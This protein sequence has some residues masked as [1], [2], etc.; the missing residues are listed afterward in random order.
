MRGHA[1]VTAPFTAAAVAERCGLDVK[2][3]ERGLTMLE[4]SGFV[5]RGQ[6]S[7][8]ALEVDEF[9]DRR[10]LARI[11]RYTLDRLRREI[12]PVAK[13]DYMRFLLRWHGIT[14]SERLEGRGGLRQALSKLQGFEA[15]AGAW[16]SELLAARVKDY[17]PSWL[18]ELCLAGEVSWARLTPRRPRINEDGEATVTT[19]AATR[20]TPVTL[21]LRQDLGTLLAATRGIGRGW[22]ADSG[23]GA[24]P[25]TGAAAEVLSTL[26]ER[27]AL[28]FDEIVTSTRR[29]ATDVE[30][31]LRELIGGGWVTA[32]GFQG[33]REIA[34]GRKSGSRNGRRDRWRRARRASAYTHGM[35]M[36]GGPPGRWSALATPEIDVPGGAIDEDDLAEAVAT[37]LLDRYGVVFRDLM[38]GESLTI[39]WRFVLRAL[40]RFEARG[41]IRGGRFV[42]GVVGEQYALPEAVEQ[43]RQVRREPRDGHRTSISA[44]DPLNLT[45]HVLPGERVPAQRGRTIELVD[46]LPVEVSRTRP[47][48]RPAPRAVVSAGED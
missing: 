17:Q 47:R 3:A 6:F 45:G 29:L 2:D 32:D 48:E 11:H 7:T 42:A 23:G 44:V 9:C 33:L 41:T 5:L 16:E 38:R 43:L 35:F 24:E 26:R 36:G 21:T 15:P 4:A 34:G 31:G 8:P 25:S 22:G 37:I 13:Q 1:E 46:G 12:D 19:T 27:G 28:F 14:E 20:A 30:Q 40:R 18:D 10:L 39:P